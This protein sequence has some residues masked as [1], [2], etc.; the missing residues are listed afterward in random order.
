MPFG[1][2]HDTNQNKRY[3]INGNGAFKAY[4]D[5]INVTDHINNDQIIILYH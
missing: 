5:F 2:N 4:D 1:F 3:A